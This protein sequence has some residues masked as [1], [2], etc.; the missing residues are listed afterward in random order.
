VPLTSKLRAAVTAGFAVTAVAVP[1]AL[2]PS[3]AAAATASTARA[4]AGAGAAPTTGAKTSKAILCLLN[5][6]RTRRG[7]PPLRTDPRLA[8]AARGHS[9]DMVQRRF[10]EHT[11]PG[12]VTFV[13][14]IQRQRY[15]AGARNWTVGENLA[16]GTG[17]LATPRKI[18]R[19]WMNS[20]GHRA[21][22]LSPRFREIGI[23]IARGVPVA[24][25][26]NG[27]HAGATFTTD[28]GAR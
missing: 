1:V 22:I 16:W 4:C 27:A 2:V 28:F 14:R 19:G 18:V 15:T 26:A 7:L 6:E 11:A 23:G 3:P 17:T 9:K 20:P 24:G 12:D 10:F 21:N 8:K 13:E 5:K 25:A